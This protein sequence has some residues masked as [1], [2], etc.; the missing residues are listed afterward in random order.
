M[1]HGD[2][3]VNIT[4]PWVTLFHSFPT[5]ETLEVDGWGLATGLWKGL[6]IASRTPEANPGV[7]DLVGPTV[8]CH[9]LHTI[10]LGRYLR[11]DEQL[12]DEIVE[13]LRVRA[14]RGTR[15][16]ELYMMLWHH[17]HQDYAGMKETY[18]PL[19]QDLVEE[20]SYLSATDCS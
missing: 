7:P 19:L 11:V 20:V 4:L 5:L 8:V 3:D 17:H 13:C 9:G 14:D 12:L 2:L 10:R 18:V 1:C 15:L 16:R 6:R